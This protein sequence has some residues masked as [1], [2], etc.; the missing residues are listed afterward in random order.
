MCSNNWNTH[1]NIAIGDRY[2][3][4]VKD[5]LAGALGREIG[6]VQ[7]PGIQVSKLLTWPGLT[8]PSVKAAGAAGSGARVARGK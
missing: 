7:C 8:E 5:D 3:R 1:A 4:L 6:P 2:D